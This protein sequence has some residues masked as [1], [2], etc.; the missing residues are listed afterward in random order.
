MR[1]GLVLLH[2]EH[3]SAD[4]AH[5]ELLVALDGDLLDSDIGHGGAA[6]PIAKKRDESLDGGDRSL[7]LY[8]HAPVL[9][10]AHPAE[11]AELMRP[12]PSGVPKG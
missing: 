3:S 12:V 7:G 1:G 2:D 6:R 8:S 5:S 9:A 10:V 4:A 11:H